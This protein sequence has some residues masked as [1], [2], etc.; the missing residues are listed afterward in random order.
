VGA[1][2]EEFILLDCAHGDLCKID[3]HSPAYRA[4]RGSIK[5]ILNSARVRMLKAVEGQEQSLE[6][7]SLVLNSL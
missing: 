2:Q 6:L 7:V 1:D 4:I 5:D 3:V